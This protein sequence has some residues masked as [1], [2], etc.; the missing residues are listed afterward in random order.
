MNR[1]YVVAFLIGLLFAMLGA[2]ANPVGGG[3]AL[4][5]HKMGY[6]GR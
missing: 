4:L 1:R 2:K 5:M 6:Y 3:G